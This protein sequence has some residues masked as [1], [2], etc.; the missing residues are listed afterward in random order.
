M[1]LR[2]ALVAHYSFILSYLVAGIMIAALFT[3]FDASVR[4]GIPERP[5]LRVYTSFGSMAEII[6]LVG[7][8]VAAAIGSV[9]HQA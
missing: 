1:S 2:I 5:T 9:L 7:S 8:L 4:P 6:K 3:M